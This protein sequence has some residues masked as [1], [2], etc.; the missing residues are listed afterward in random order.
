MSDKALWLIGLILIFSSSLWAQRFESGSTGADGALST[1]T[2]G[3]IWINM[4]DRPNGVYN[5]TEVNIREGQT[6][7]F[8]PNQKNRPVVWLVK[9][10]VIINGRVD[11]SGEDANPNP[12]IA[13]AGG[14]GGWP[15]GKKG[16]NLELYQGL[17]PG[18]GQISAG[19]NNWGSGGGHANL[20][21]DS[22]GN[23][24][25]GA[26]YGNQFCI[27]LSGGSGGGAGDRSVNDLGGG[28][29]GAILIAASGMILI[30]GGS[31][32]GIFA[33]GGLPGYNDVQGGGSGGTIRLVSNSIILS[34]QAQIQAIFPPRE[35]TGKGYV[36]LEAYRLEV[37]GAQVKG[38]VS[39]GFPGPLFE[40]PAG[41]ATLKIKSVAGVEVGNDP[42]GSALY[43]DIDIPVGVPNPVEIVVEGTGLDDGTSITLRIHADQEN[44][45]RSIDGRLS[46]NKTLTT[47]KFFTN[48]PAGVGTL[49]VR[50]K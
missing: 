28:G 42:G 4:A 32:S 14:P 13:A 11:V 34:G 40:L 29:G 30:T 41:S 39:R 37:P 18:G 21:A 31:D 45:F 48:L 22:W 46:G 12:N 49:Y 3:I 27:P 50:T 16:S 24:T 8:I 6:I 20:G 19:A 1:T 36:R 43:P 35:T 5:Y 25:R 17:G 33:N 10:D 23:P 38:Y 15:G 9:G 44:A 7:K 26:I 2:L 47:C